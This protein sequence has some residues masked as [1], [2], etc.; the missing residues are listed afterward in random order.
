MKNTATTTTTETTS[1][2]IDT[3]YCGYELRKIGETYRAWKVNSQGKYIYA[4]NLDELKSK[5]R[6]EARKD[7]AAATKKFEALKAQAEG[8]KTEQDL[9]M[10]HI[11]CCTAYGDGEIGSSQ[12]EELRD[13]MIDRRDWYGFAW[14]KGI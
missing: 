4:E 5:V 9:K 3:G 1:K 10:A 7:V 8:I 6:K 2:I 13:I 11:H 12:F 14:G